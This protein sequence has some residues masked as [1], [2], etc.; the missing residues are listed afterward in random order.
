MENNKILVGAQFGEVKENGNYNHINLELYVLRDILLGQ[1]LDGIW[2]GLLRMAEEDPEYGTVYRYCSEIFSKSFQGTWKSDHLNFD[3]ITLTSYSRLSTNAYNLRSGRFV[4]GPEDMSKPLYMLG[5]VPSSRIVFNAEGSCPLLGELKPQYVIEAF[6]PK[7]FLGHTFPEYNISSRQLYRF[8][9]TPIK[10]IPP[11]DPPKR[12]NRSLA[13]VLLPTLITMGVMIASRMIMSSRNVG[14]AVTMAALS[15]AM[16]LTAVVTT[17]MNWKRGNREYEEN[18]QM[19][20]TQYEKY[21]DEILE[22]IQRRQKRDTEKMDELYPDMLT[23]IRKNENG[24]YSLNEKLYSRASGD[25]DFLK[26]RIGISDQVPSKFEVQGEAREVI[27]SQA[28]FELLQEA[29]G[30]EHIRLYTNE[31]LKNHAG[32]EENLC[33]LPI[34]LAERFAFL[35]NAPLL[36]SLRDKGSLGIVDYHVGELPSLS[37]YFITRMIYEL[38]FYHSPSDLQFVVFFNGN[39]QWKQMENVIN[40]YKFMPHFHGLFSDKSQFVFDRKSAN[41]VFSSLLKL[42]NSRSVQRREEKE[43]PLPHVVMIVFEEFGLKEHAF[44]EYLPK[45]PKE[46]TAYENTI[47]LTF[48]FV[49]KY[50]EYLPAYCDDIINFESSEMTITPREDISGRKAFRYDAWTSAANPREYYKTY[51]EE[52]THAFRFFSAVHY[53]QIAQNGKVPSYVR[54]FDLFPGNIRQLVEQN[55]GIKGKRTIQGVTKQLKVP[56]GR[57][58]SMVSYLDLHEKADGPHM[59]VAGTTGSGKTETVISYLIGLCMQYRPD[60]LNLLLID[61]KGGGFTKRLGGLPHVVGAVTDVD[62]DENGTGAEYMLKRFLN[63]MK[64]EIKRRKLLFNTLHVDSVDAYIDACNDI[65]G[66]IARKK[67]SDKEANRLRELAKTEKLSHLLLVVDEFTEL[68]RFTQESGDLDFMGQIT[69][70]AR[71]GRSLGFHIILISQNIEGAITDDIRANINARLCLKVATKQASKD[72]LG[73]ELA[74]SPYMP[75]NGRAY[76]L[77]GTGA[78]FEYFQSAY[79]GCGETEENSVEITLAS[80]TGQYRS[81]YRSDRDNVEF[82]KNKIEAKRQGTDRSQLEVA[83]EAIC[84][85]YRRSCRESDKPHM[86]FCPPLPERLAW[87]NGT[88]KPICINEQKE[89]L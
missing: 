31:S 30:S 25:G 81:F 52:M 72:M 45:A 11:S 12:P 70:I 77:V 32:P 15:M 33:R 54:L 51:M 40:N 22:K 71:V 56:I 84:D 69:A 42:F 79:S 17:M 28:A 13:Y 64:Y 21:I 63:A 37:H 27:F 80:K 83:V 35:H 46:G 47:G 41:L 16:G 20:H 50:K 82:R 76:L 4:F 75:G 34:T 53:A 55:W 67:I 66:H 9:A 48:V 78:K 19:W 57:T 7:V 44:A 2:Y 49:K 14:S 88:R 87:D 74:A 8:D 59:L 24:I 85:V 29:D 5:I 58:E 89:E 62:G 1:F 26:F 43:R 86:I 68:K 23:L 36:Y 61:M 73:T 38:C 10:I 6:S 65:E 60:E 3:Q 18:L 39:N